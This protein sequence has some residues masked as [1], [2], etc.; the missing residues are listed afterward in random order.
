M[1]SNNIISIENKFWFRRRFSYYC[2]PL[3]IRVI[4]TIFPYILLIILS[5]KSPQNVQIKCSVSMTVFDIIM[6]IISIVPLIVF[7]PLGVLTAVYQYDLFEPDHR[8]LNK[9]LVLTGVHLLIIILSNIAILI[10]FVYNVCF[11]TI[12]A[13]PSIIIIIMCIIGAALYS[14]RYLCTKM[15]YCMAMWSSY[16][17]DAY[18]LFGNI[19]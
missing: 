3:V 5:I 12:F 7:L 2:L 14:L 18:A 19:P 13:I 6:I 10:S 15:M 17:D 1:F 9:S 11:M 4:V 16:N 8:V